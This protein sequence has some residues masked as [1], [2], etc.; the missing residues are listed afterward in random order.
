MKQPADAVSLVMIDCDGTLFDSYEANRSFYDEVLRS[1]GRS[2]L[3]AEGRDLAH[4]MATPLLFAHLF[5]DDPVGLEQATRMARRT[6]YAPYLELM[7]PVP[8]LVETLDW[9]HARHRT[10]LATNRGASITRLL[11]HFDLLPH[12]DLVDGIHDV[13]RPKPAPDMLLHCLAHFD[14]PAAQSIYV[15]DS[16]GDRAASRAAGVRFVSVDSRVPGDV[17]LAAFADLVSLLA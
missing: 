3:D 5:R 14:A 8:G 12:F 10:A 15:G 17:D 9:V 2:P 1:I 6:D 16:S 4:H 13:A 11:G 7:T